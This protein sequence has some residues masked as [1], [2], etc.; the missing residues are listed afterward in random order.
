M[1]SGY[2]IATVPWGVPADRNETTRAKIH[3]ARLPSFLQPV[4]VVL[5][6]SIT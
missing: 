2:G 3:A 1:R 5:G 4:I 6:G